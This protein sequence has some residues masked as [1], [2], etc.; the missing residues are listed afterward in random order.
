MSEQT[1]QSDP[2]VMQA[3]R[4]RVLA[5]GGRA[6]CAA[7]A[8][9][10]PPGWCGLRPRGHGPDDHAGQPTG[11]RSCAQAH[12]PPAVFR[13]TEVSPSLVSRRPRGPATV[14]RRRP[15]FCGRSHQFFR[16]GEDRSPGLSSATISR[17]DTGRRQDRVAC[18]RLGGVRETPLDQV[19]YTLGW[20]SRPQ[21]YAAAVE[22]MKTAL[23]ELSKLW[24]LVR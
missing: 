13:R 16:D 18:A 6:A 10:H 7:H 15:D 21:A 4:A 3:M 9:T 17:G 20:G 22:R 12:Y 1:R 11:T 8:R 23:D 2:G 19:G 24:G 14:D 5:T